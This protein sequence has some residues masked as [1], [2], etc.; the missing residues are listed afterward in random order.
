MYIDSSPGYMATW[1]RS[2]WLHG[3]LCIYLEGEVEEE[4]KANEDEVGSQVPDGGGDPVDAAVHAAHQLQVQAAHRALLDQ[5]QHKAGHHKSQVEDGGQ[6]VDQ[7]RVALPDNH[8]YPLQLRQ[9]EWC[10][11]GVQTCRSCDSHMTSVYGI[12]YTE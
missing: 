12:N 5:Q 10:S 8:K 6:W 7:E 4:D 1:K 2:R 9:L 11:I 3:Y